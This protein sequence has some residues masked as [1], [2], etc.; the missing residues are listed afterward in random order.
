MSYYCVE[1][2][3]ARAFSFRG[4]SQPFQESRTSFSGVPGLLFFVMVTSGMAADG[5]G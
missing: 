4:M 1:S 3:G 2:F 5:A